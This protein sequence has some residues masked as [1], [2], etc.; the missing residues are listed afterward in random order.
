MKILT[1]KLYD[2]T[3]YPYWIFFEHGRFSKPFMLLDDA[4][5]RDLIRQV[6]IQDEKKIEKE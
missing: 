6:N 1:K 3:G 4:E 5:L 2:H